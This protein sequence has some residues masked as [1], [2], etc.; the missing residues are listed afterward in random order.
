MLGGPNDALSKPKL[1]NMFDAVFVSTRTAHCLDQPYFTPLLKDGAVVAVESSKFVVPLPRKAKAEFNTK[2]VDYA[3]SH[4]LT[5]MVP[6]KLQLCIETLSASSIL[7][8]ALIESFLSRSFLRSTCISAP[9][10]RE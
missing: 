6:G 10:R 5:R 2:V 4:G 3:K 9:K 8:A 1:A 7:A